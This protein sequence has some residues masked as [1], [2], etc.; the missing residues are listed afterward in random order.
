MQSTVTTTKPNSFLNN[1][2]IAAG[3]VIAISL[4]GVFFARFGLLPSG[5]GQ[6]A[7]TTHTH[8]VRAEEM[9]FSE[10]V[11]RL[12][13]GETVTLRLENGDIYVHSFDVDELGVHAPMPA[14][15]ATTVTFTAQEPGEFS[16]YCGVPGHT[17][18]G[19]VGTIIVEP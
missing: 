7:G 19:M 6:A 14:N 16:F 12:R 10:G 18:A 1:M 15:Q 11:L 3:I 13:V 17:E 5:N 9:R 4:V 8:Q 2:L